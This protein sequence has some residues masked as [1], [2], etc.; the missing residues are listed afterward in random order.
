MR[1]QHHDILLFTGDSV[2]ACERG[3]PIGERYSLGYGYVSL[4]NSLLACCCPDQVVRVLNTGVNGNR[5]F[6]LENR[7]QRDVID[8]EPDWLSVMIGI[9]DVWRQFDHPGKADQVTRDSYRTTYQRM[10]EQVRSS[11]KGLVLM[12]PFYLELNTEDSMRK[13][14]DVY[15]GIVRELAEEFDAIFVDTQRAFDVLLQHRPNQS[16]AWDRVHPNQT[17]HVILATAFLQQ[18]GVDFQQLCQF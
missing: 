1:L 6:E 12:T 3:L 5:V 9:N 8:I 15:G 13:E 14:M 16:I 4:I 2:T 7:W 17:G 18:M 11:L 10:L